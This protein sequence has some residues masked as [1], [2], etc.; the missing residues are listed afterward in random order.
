[1]TS[2][3]NTPLQSQSH[4]QAQT[5]FVHSG[6]AFQTKLQG[7]KDAEIP[8]MQLNTDAILT[9]TN[10]LENITTHQLQKATSQDEHLQNLKEHIIQG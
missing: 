1:M 10:I 6:L 3:L 2:T 9:T 8:C 4:I 7:K 5:R